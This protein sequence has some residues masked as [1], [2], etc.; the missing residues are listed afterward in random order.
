MRLQD[1]PAKQGGGAWLKRLIVGVD[2]PRARR[3]LQTEVPGEVYDASTTGISEVVVH[4][5]PTA[6]GPLFRGRA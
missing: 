4:F 2:S 1:V 5:S 3:N 6:G